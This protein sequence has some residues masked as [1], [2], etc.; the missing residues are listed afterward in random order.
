M[1]KIEK[2]MNSIKDSTCPSDYSMKERKPCDNDCDACWNAELEPEER[3][4][5]I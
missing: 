1:T 5:S 2:I 4:A 3:E